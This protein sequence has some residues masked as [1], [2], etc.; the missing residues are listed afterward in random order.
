MSA[1][2]NF[3]LLGIKYEAAVLGGL[4]KPGLARIEDQVRAEAGDS[5]ESHPMIVRGRNAV[6]AEHGLAPLGEPPREGVRDA[7]P[8]RRSAWRRLLGG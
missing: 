2:K 8:S 3:V 7:G 4:D 1:E 6:R 5:W